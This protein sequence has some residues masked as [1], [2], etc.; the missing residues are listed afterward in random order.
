MTVTQRDQITV[1]ISVADDAR[2]DGLV[3]SDAPYASEFEGFPDEGL[4]RDCPVRVVPAQALQELLKE[5]RSFA[6]IYEKRFG[7]VSK[8]DKADILALF[9]L[10]EEERNWD[11]AKRQEYENWTLEKR[12]A[13]REEAGTRRSPGEDERR[14]RFLANHDMA[15]LE[16]RGS[17]HTVGGMHAITDRLS[18]W[19]T[20]RVWRDKRT[21]ALALGILAEDFVGALHVLL[22]LNLARS[23]S[24]AVCARC[25]A[26][27]T[28]TMTTQNYC[29]LR[30]GNA[31]R[32]ARQRKKAE[33]A[34][35]KK[36]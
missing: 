24:L 10:V 8:R 35:G 16:K 34:E 33:V 26:R 1:L 17:V 11:P 20:L 31:A 5:S 9:A 30:C 19:A 36:R 21:A 4:H 28:R 22:L 18:G 15:C 23:E 14:A 7:Q 25:R 2:N 32:K 13:E 27:Y 6:A 29:S 3:F 12:R